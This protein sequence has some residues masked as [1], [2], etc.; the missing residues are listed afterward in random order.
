MYMIEFWI[1]NAFIVIIRSNLHT[2]IDDDIV[3]PNLAEISIR[4]WVDNAPEGC[5]LS[6]E[7]TASI[8]APYV[9][10]QPLLW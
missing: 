9:P 5:F 1:S 2:T 8:A 10:L 4:A 3:Q 7:L 6:H